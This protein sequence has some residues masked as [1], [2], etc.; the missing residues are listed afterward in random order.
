MENLYIVLEDLTMILSHSNNLDTY[1]RL[2]VVITFIYTIA[3]IFI[4]VFNLKS[5]K[6]AREQAAEQKRQFDETNRPVVDFTI[7]PMQGAALGLVFQNTGKKLAREICVEIN[8][9][10]INKLEEGRQRYIVNLTKSNFILGINQSK[11]AGFCLVSSQS[12]LLNF[13]SSIKPLKS[14]CLSA[15]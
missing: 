14:F 9:D 6:A 10:F 2:M 15:S 5:A 3:T 12:Y 4:C 7:E 13:P 1:P 11:V 8:D